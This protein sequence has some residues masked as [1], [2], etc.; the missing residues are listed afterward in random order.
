MKDISANGSLVTRENPERNIKEIVSYKFEID[1]P[2]DRLISDKIRGLNIFQCIGQFLWITQG[3][4][5]LEAIKYYQP[6]SDKFSSDGI[7][8]IGAYGPR[9]FGIQHLNQ[10]RHIIDI[11]TKDSGKRRAVASVYLPQFDQHGLPKEEVPCTLNLQ[12]LVRDNKLQ[13]VTYMRS[14]DVFKVLPYDFF[15]FTMLQ[16]YLLNRLRT[17]YLL[18][19]LGSEHLEF[20]LGRYN[21]Y[22]GSFHVYQKD[23]DT[24][25]Q[26][27][28]NE[29]AETI[30]M[31]KMPQKDVELRL[32]SLNRFES[33][34]RMS[35]ASKIKYGLQFNFDSM[36]NMMNN[37]LKDEYW[38]QLG[39]ILLSYSAINT[40]DKENY[41]KIFGLLH[42][43]YQHFVKFYIDKN[44]L[45][46]FY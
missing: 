3:N 19:E 46:E 42:P 29:S 15:I 5:N 35:T 9:L 37:M 16:E 12:Y 13:A 23:L 4:F 27:I 6:S 28:E 20:Q 40:K 1:D 41:K 21:H 26:V 24:I 31:K 11:L 45:T 33:I 17:E 36:Q 22:S 18:K 7:K 39:L 8:V 2:R 30:K 34:V 32:R 43:E 14:Q 44:E 38:I 10:M 25:K